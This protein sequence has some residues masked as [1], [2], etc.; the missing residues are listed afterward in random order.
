MPCDYLY[1]VWVEAFVLETSSLS[2]SSMAVLSCACVR[3]CGTMS[4]KK[5]FYGT[6]ILCS[7]VYGEL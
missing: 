6:I 1:V 3:V 5:M 7:L 4:F 2:Y